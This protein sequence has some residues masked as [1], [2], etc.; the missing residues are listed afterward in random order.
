MGSISHSRH[1]WSEYVGTLNWRSVRSVELVTIRLR[2]R[3]ASAIPDS[4]ACKSEWR[5]PPPG[6][7]ELDA[8]DAAHRGNLIGDL[9]SADHLSSERR[10]CA[11]DVSTGKRWEEMGREGARTVFVR[12]LN[13]RTDP[14]EV[15]AKMCFPEG[16]KRA[17][18]IADLRDG[19]GKLGS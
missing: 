5:H 14:V 15:P 13:T 12:V 1:H 11:C 17:T 8:A 16:S 6:L 4:Q 10:T 7:G 9:V 3:R 2:R 19:R 18:V